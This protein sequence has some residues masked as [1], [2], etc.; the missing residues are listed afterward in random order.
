M[1]VA[2]KKVTLV[3]LASRRAES[4]RELRRAGVMHVQID[5]ATGSGDQAVERLRERRT[6]VNRAIGLLTLEKGTP[7]AGAAAPADPLEAARA[8][9]DGFEREQAGFEQVTQLKRLESSLEPWGEFSPA[10]VRELEA[11][12]VSVRL[13]T[14]SRNEAA[15]LAAEPALAD[16]A[17]V[18][19]GG[20]AGLQRVA[21]LARGALQAALPGAELPLP[22]RGLTEVRAEISRLQEQAAALRRARA[23]AAA[24]APAMRKALAALDREIEL[25]RVT[26]GMAAEGPLVHLTGYVPAEAVTGLETRAASGGWALLIEDPA[27]DDPVPTLVRNPAWVRIVQPMFD[28]LG[29]T[30][31][32]GE[33]DIS[34]SFLMFYTVFWAMIVG[35]AG[36][37][38]VYLGFIIW[39]RSRMRA[40]PAE[41]FRMVYVMS[42]ATIIWGA[43]TGTWFGS[44]DLAQVPLLHALTIQGIA[45]FPA[46]GGD[47]S[48]TIMQ[49]CFVIAGVHLSLA[50][51]LSL[52]RKIKGLDALAELG[53]IAV[54]WGMFFVVQFMVLGKP[55]GEPALLI[56]PLAAVPRGQ[57]ATYL[58]LGGLVLVVLFQEQKGKVIKGALMGVAWLPM[59]L[60]GAIS[61]FADTVSY[62]RLFAVGLAGVKVAEVFNT[63]A[64]AVM[65]NAPPVGVLILVLGH[66]LNLT[67][68]SM[69]LLVH[70]V[71]LKVLEFSQ[72]LG[73]E[74][75]GMAY[76]PFAEE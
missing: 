51:I 73:M 39:L 29:I 1:I 61:A 42:T 53:W 55:A 60:M 45:S 40:A 20:E 66:A 4:L 10:A 41:F 28:F 12:G 48:A 37:G 46:D 26:L 58:V 7:R 22:E 62:V 17:V 36:Y 49:V 8:V 47:T 68:G 72:H 19:V 21:V 50:H 33:H 9:V 13:A 3:A 70:G 31:G 6:L 16:A 34:L 18:A 69:A 76:A 59:R 38:L 43:I 57:L 14:M 5:P 54:L 2:M 52:V 25:E 27:D 24:A 74:W 75:K 23:D 63:M 11:R 56:G 65:A 44:R 64:L 71:R 67:L 15:G 35:D 32:Y 30:P